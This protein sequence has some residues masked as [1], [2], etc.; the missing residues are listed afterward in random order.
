AHPGPA[1]T[2]RRARAEGRDRPRRPGR[3]HRPPG[4]SPG[5]R[6]RHS[7]R[8]HARGPP[9]SREVG[10]EAMT[11]SDFAIKRPIV[12]IVAMLVLV[13]FGLFALFSIDVDEFPDLTN[14]IVFLAVP[15][16]GASP[17]QV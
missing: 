10:A 12:T 15:Y 11:I 2:H 7:R 1:R 6:P 8:A 16:P 14:L 4:R 13:I 9:G 17:S 5:D 3:R